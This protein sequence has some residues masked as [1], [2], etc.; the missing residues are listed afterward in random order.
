MLRERGAAVHC[1]LNSWQNER[2]VPLVEDVGASWST[3]YYLE[4]LDRHARNPIALAK[5]AWDV[6]MTSFGLLR[7]AW[8]FRATHVFVPELSTAIRNAPALVV[9]RLLGRPVI[10]RVPNAPDRGRFYE[11]LWR[12][13]LPPLVSRVVVNSEFSRAGGLA[14]R[15]FPNPSS[16]ARAQLRVV[17]RKRETR[18]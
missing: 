15:A 11:V 10:L 16:E 9:L 6:L 3:G 1:I 13:I 14:S 8:R 7:D 2:I 17:A 5:V 18:R 12:R 4:T